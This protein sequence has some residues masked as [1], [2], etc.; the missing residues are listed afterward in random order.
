MVLN[1]SCI[2]SGNEV[3]QQVEIEQNEKEIMVLHE[4]TT[5]IK[6]IIVVW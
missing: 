1:R 2:I 4:S 3:E 5:D 6:T